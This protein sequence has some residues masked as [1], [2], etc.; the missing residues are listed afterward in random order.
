[1]AFGRGGWFGQGLGNSIQKLSYLPEAHTDFVFAII[2]EELGFI[3]VILILLVSFALVLQAL[4]IARRCINAKQYFG[5]YFAFGIVFWFTFQILVNVGAA[6]GIVPT[7]GLTLPFI[8]Y[9]GSSLFV[10][11]TAISILIRIDYEYRLSQLNSGSE[12][13][14]TMDN[15]DN[16][17][18]QE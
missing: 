3:G 16:N 13:V 15:N 14:V 8:S 6:A 1:M 7:K 10:M 18:E 4:K 5:G 17:N 11:A 9:G 2:A 12:P